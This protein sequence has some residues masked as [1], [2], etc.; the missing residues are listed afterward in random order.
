[1][2]VIKIYLILLATACVLGLIGAYRG[3]KILLKQN[4]T[5]DIKNGSDNICSAINS[6][7]NSVAETVL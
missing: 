5:E 6:E 3:S 4:M 1:M 7:N 2:I